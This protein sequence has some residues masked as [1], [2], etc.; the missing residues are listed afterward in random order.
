MKRAV[1]VLAA[2]LFAAVGVSV[3][4]RPPAPAFPHETHARLF[5]VCEGCHAGVTTG[6]PDDLY[7]RERDCLQCHDGVRADPVEWSPPGGRGSN[8]RFFHTAHREALAG[9]GDAAACLRCHAS[10]E[11][12]N[13]MSVSAARPELCIQCHAHAAEGHLAEAAPCTQCH[14]PLAEARGVPL[15]RV[16]GF[17]RP[18]GHE[19]PDFLSRHA[20]GDGSDLLTCS[21]CHARESCERCHANA[22]RLPAVAGL[23]RDP[24]VASLVAGRAPEYPSPSSHGSSS[25]GWTHGTAAQSAPDT[26]ANCHTRPSCSGCHGEGL[27]AAGGIV[28]TLPAAQPGRARGVQIAVSASSAHPGDFSERHGSWAASGALDCARCHAKAYCADC[29][30]GSTSREF[31]PANFLE[32]HAVEVFSRGSD[33]QSCHSPEAFCQSCHTSSGVASG[34]RMAAAFHTAEPMWVL[35]HGQAARRGLDSCASC[36]RQE[37]CLQCHSAAGGWGVNPHGPGFAAS[38]LSERS[39][40]TCRMCHFGDPMGR[41]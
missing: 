37:D 16:A 1:L 19:S 7:P 9:G 18:P 17:P 29:H 21:V 38:R 32:R 20:P 15:E 8:L 11:P 12:R 24:R 22:E 27:A 35:T 34:G 6:A 3:A 41:N 14:V 28:S 30:A 26:C 25:W 36:H 39:A 5:P 23:P 33:C 31:H 40:R 2:V 4:S 13:R 10:V